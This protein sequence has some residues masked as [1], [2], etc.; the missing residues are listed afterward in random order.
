[1]QNTRFEPR[2]ES[3]PS[4]WSSIGRVLEGP[5]AWLLTFVVIPALVIA[6]LL[7]PP[8]SLMSRL[9]AFTYT[10]IGVAGGAIRDPDGTIV[11]FP[12]EGIQRGFL[13]TIESTPR[14]EFIEGQAGR[15]LY[16]AARDLPDYLIPKSPFYKVKLIGTEPTQVILEIPIPNDSLPYETLGV[17]SYRDGRWWHLPNV[18]YPADDII[19]SRLEFVPP[20]FMVM[21]TVAVVPAVSVD[22]GLEGQLPQNAMV[23]NEIK[24]GLYLRGDGALEGVAPVNTGNTL[25]VIRNWVDDVVRTDLINNLLLDPGLQDNQLVAVEQTVVQNGYPG[26][27]IDYRGVDAVPSARADFVHLMSRLAERLHA[28]NKTLAVRVERPRQ[29]SADTWDTTGYDWEGLGQV[30]DTLIIPAPVDPRAYAPNGEMEALLDFAT[31]RVERRKIQFELTA[32]SIERSGNYLLL[33][34]YQESLQPLVTQIQAEVGDDGNVVVSLDNPRIQERVTWD[35]AIGMYTYT[36]VDDQGLQRTVYIE[37]ASSLARK[38]TLLQR[39]HVRG[40]SVVTPP[41]GD[42]DPNIWNVLLQFQQGT[43][44]SG[45]ANQMA[46]AY[47]VYGPDGNVIAQELRPLDDPRLAFAAPAGQGELRVDAQIVGGNGQPLTALQSTTLALGAQAVAEEAPAEAVAAAEEAPAEEVV[48]ASGEPTLSSGQV[49]NVRE[50]PSTAYNVLGQITPGNTYRIKAQNENRDW[51]QIDFNGQ[52]GWVIGQLV[53]TSGNV[54]AVAVTS[55]YPEPPAQPVAAAAAPAAAP[56]VA[57]PA[58]TGGGSF[59]YGVQAH[60]VHND[61]AGQVMAMTRD[62]G[63]NWV[64]QQV[65]WKVFE[66]SPGQRDFGALD[67][68]VNAANGAGINLLF[69]VVN[70]PGWAREPGFDASVGGPPQN[71]QT[72]ADFLGALAGKYCGSSV[73]AIEVWNEQNLHYEWGN[74]PLNPADY[75]ALLAPSYA[76]IKA[77]CPSMYVISGALTPA[78]D[79]PGLAVDDFAYLEGMFQ[80]GLNNYIDGVGAHPSGYN[81]PPSVTWEGACEA[82]QRHGNSFNGACDSPHHSWSFRSTM[83]GYRNIMVKYGAGN[84]KIWPTE[85]GWAAGGAFHPAYKYADDNDFNEQAQWTV[86]AFQM[87]KSWGWVGPAFLWNLNF[88][89]VANGTEKAQWGIVGPNWEPLPVYNALKSMPK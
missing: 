87:M 48:A 85:F 40:V 41:S 61:Q 42:V 79:N 33:K 4:I 36:Y 54:D 66:P 25:P 75:V 51:W 76:A 70:A 68:I 9:Q 45:V 23:A 18:V 22:L 1:M 53:N 60:M 29:I 27:V 15:E 17:Y 39:F 55:D 5:A 67:G 63:F 80:A 65:E 8:I 72:F 26:V 83:E 2:L 35:D 37:T 74:R 19:E 13:A 3:R 20:N 86:E 62:L 34:G 10:R 30:V 6:A 84:K 78:G 71:P 77:A 58:P 89:V 32:Q 28:N 12:A 7:L 88:R 73:K 59:G 82:I 14:A 38:L 47:T 21:Q 57:A 50:G 43:D 69:S 52:D 46:I 44:L 16:E 49:V 11:N 24:A 64:K 56:A 81:V 31:S